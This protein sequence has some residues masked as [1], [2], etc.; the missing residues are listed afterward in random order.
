[1]TGYG[2]NVIISLKQRESELVCECRPGE[3]CDINVTERPGRQIEVIVTMPRPVV[4]ARD[5]EVYGAAGTYRRYF[6][7]RATAERI[8][9]AI[10]SIV[11]AVMREANEPAPENLNIVLI[12]AATLQKAQNLIVGCSQCVGT[13]SMLFKSILD[14]VTKADP[15]LTRYVLERDPICT[16]CGRS[17]D[18]DTLVEFQPVRGEEI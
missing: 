12:D 10:S 3:F 17:I 14:G 11:A 8:H 7:R 6:E 13:A 9:L 15:Q 5:W 18:G 2:K 1:V 4:E 16:R